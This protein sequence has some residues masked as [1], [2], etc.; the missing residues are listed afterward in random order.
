MRLA[1]GICVQVH[2][3]RQPETF[4]RWFYQ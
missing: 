2:Q 1:L 3:Y 4:P